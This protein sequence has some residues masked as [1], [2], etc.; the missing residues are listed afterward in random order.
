M[1]TYTLIGATTT[2]AARVQW[3]LEELGV[4]FDHHNV[5]PHDIAVTQHYPSGKV[6]VLL[7]DGQP[8]TDS[9]AILQYLADKH[10]KFTF[11]PGT[12]DRARQDALTHAI[13]DEF[14]AVLWTAARHSFILP[15]DKRVPDVKESLRWEFARNQGN[16]VKRMGDTPYLMGDEITVP[17]ILLA[18]CLLWARAAKFDVTEPE[19]LAFLGRMRDRPAFKRVYAKP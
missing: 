17:D 18:H 14:D 12:I 3:M 16:F 1:T 19:L 7:V 15:E 5:K 2:R 9:A 4:P 13:L 8:I 6:P 10:G 11:A